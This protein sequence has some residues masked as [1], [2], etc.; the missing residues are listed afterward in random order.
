M[1]QQQELAIKCAYAD[2]IGA[3]QNYEQHTYH[4]HDWD[5]HRLTIE[6]LEAEFDFLTQ[7]NEDN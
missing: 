3:L 7:S 2:L 6:E 5:A 4:D 1:T